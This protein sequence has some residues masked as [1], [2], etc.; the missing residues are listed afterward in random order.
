MPK[1][2]NSTSSSVV[3]MS[4]VAVQRGMPFHSSVAASKGAIE[5]LTK[6]LAAEY[7]PKVRVNA[8]A[9]SMLY[10]QLI[11]FS[12]MSLKLKSLLKNTH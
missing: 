4:T 11:D 5:G 1:L 9:P 8:V 12:I 6:S 2:T 7:A 3:L 10:T